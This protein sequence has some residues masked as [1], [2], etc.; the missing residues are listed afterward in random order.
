[1]KHVIYG[2]CER[3][4]KVQVLDS[5]NVVAEYSAGNSAADSQCYVEPGTKGSLNLAALRYAVLVT[6]VQ[7]AQEH[8]IENPF[9]DFTE[10]TAEQMED[11]DLHEQLVE[12]L[13]ATEDEE[14]DDSEFDI[15]VWQK[16]E[17][18]TLSIGGRSLC[19]DAPLDAALEAVRVVLEE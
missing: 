6:A 12:E 19:V 11:E 1:M 3:G 7:M 14:D 8:G 2:V 5:G 15:H 10:A 17:L 4:Y 18:Y 9:P 13:G 16:D